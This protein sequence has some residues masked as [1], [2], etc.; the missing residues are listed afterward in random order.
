VASLVSSATSAGPERP[1]FAA[2]ACICRSPIIETGSTAGS[3]API[4][5]LVAS[6]PSSFV[7]VSGANGQFSEAA[8]SSVTAA[9]TGE[10]AMDVPLAGAFGMPRIWAC[11]SHQ[12]DS[13][14]HT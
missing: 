14:I 2:M 12:V 11:R 6:G 7:Q 13:G 10:L 3:T 9:T 1:V 4:A 5:T 8:V